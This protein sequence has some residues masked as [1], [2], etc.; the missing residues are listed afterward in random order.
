M[1]ERVGST[2]GLCSA[3][4]AREDDMK[5]WIDTEFNEYRGALISMALVAEDGREWYGVR[6]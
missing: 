2:E 1:P 3:F 6:F 4:A 5:L